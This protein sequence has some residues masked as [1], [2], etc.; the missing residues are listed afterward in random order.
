M[1]GR[2]LF[3]TVVDEGRGERETAVA[4]TSSTTQQRTATTHKRPTEQ[5]HERTR[6][7]QQQQ[8]QAETGPESTAAAMQAGAAGGAAPA[9]PAHGEPTAEVEVTIE[10]HGLRNMDTFSKSDPMAIVY[11]QTGDSWTQV[12]VTETVRSSLLPSCCPFRSLPRP[13]ERCGAC[14]QV[15]DNLNPK[16]SKSFV[17]RYYFERTQLYKFEVYDV[18]D[19]QRRMDLSR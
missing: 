16:F 8:Q 2:E 3:A 6:S 4:R 7:G 1:S 17:L 9:A 5:L 19:E 12:G 18:D 14:A 10:C 11:A 15:W 13:T